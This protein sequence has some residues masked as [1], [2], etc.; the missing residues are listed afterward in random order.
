[1]SKGILGDR[2]P[3]PPKRHD[4]NFI[5]PGDHVQMLGLP[6]RRG[7]YVRREVREDEWV[8]KWPE[9]MQ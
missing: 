2:L 9:L 4:A 8:H 5:A 3:A 1:M 7:W 6:A